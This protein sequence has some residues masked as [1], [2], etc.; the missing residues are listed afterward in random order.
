M[1]F[2]YIIFPSPFT[3]Y[4]IV[5]ITCVHIFF[6]VFNNSMSERIK[7]KTSIT[8]LNFIII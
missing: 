7:N 2:Y 6:K 4:F 1:A 3:N 8:N 5:R